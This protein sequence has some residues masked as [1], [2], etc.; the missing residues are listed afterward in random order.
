[1]NISE[2]IHKGVN[3]RSKYITQVQQQRPE[4]HWSPGMLVNTRYINSTR[5][6]SLK[7]YFEDAPLVEFMYLVCMPGKSYLG[8]LK[9]CVTCTL[10]LI[11][12]QIYEYISSVLVA[13]HRLDSDSPSKILNLIILLKQT[14]PESVKASFES[15][16]ASFE[17]ESQL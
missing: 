7:M 10:G 12:F 4:S 14:F 17:S 9:C 6:T 11:L 5:G 13:H 15:V 2:S 16:K 8:R 3:Q 1:M